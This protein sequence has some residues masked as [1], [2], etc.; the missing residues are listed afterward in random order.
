MSS[1]PALKPRTVWHPEPIDNEPVTP[2]EVMELPRQRRAR[3]PVLYA[4][5]SILGIAIV[6]SAQLVLSIG[7][8]DGAYEISSLHQEQKDLARTAQSVQEDLDRVKSSQYLAANAEALGMV[9]NSSPVYLRL[10]DGAVLGSPIPAQAGVG[11]VIGDAGSQV[12]NSLLNGLP[13]VTQLS[14]KH[15]EEQTTQ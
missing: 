2:L 1:N 8:S 13:L 9:R 4:F 10:S 11:A 12:P 6:A 3:P 5:I 14:E 7:T 15:G